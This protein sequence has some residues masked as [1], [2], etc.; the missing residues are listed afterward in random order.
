[1]NVPLP[2]VILSFVVPALAL[3]L[4]GHALAGLMRRRAQGWRWFFGL[5]ACLKKERGCV[6]DQPQHAASCSTRRESDGCCGWSRT[7]QP[8]S[9]IFRHALS[10]LAFGILAVPLHGLPVAR[11]LAGW[12]PHWSIPTLA[13]LAAAVMHRFFG[14]ELLRPA[15]RQA[16]WIFGA[17]AGLTLYPLALGLGAFDPYSLGWYFG[18]LLAGVG[19]VTLLLHWRGNRF[20]VVLLLAVGA[21]AARVPESGN[22]WDCLVDPFYFLTALGALISGLARRRQVLAAPNSQRSPRFNT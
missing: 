16:A 12:V 10:L 20:G 3:M 22:C 1:M 17:V 4:A 11:W 7:T 5:R 14:V 9:G 21:W 13:L 15:D 19:I 18:P 6:E 2:A 8:R